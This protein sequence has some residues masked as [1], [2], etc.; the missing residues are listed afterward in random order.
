M[1]ADTSIDADS[2]VYMQAT[3][4]LGSG[5]DPAGDNR[6]LPDSY[7][8]DSLTNSGTIEVTRL[9]AGPYYGIL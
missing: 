3:H 1:T 5:S 8:V 7:Q 6:L 4:A 2:R 9:V